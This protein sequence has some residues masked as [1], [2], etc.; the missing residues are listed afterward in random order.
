MLYDEKVTKGIWL[1][2]CKTVEEGWLN[3]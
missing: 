1:T 3:L 2:C